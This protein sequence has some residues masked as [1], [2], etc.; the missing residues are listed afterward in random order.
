MRYRNSAQSYDYGDQYATTGEGTYDSR[1]DEST[2]DASYSHDK[3]SS[4]YTGASRDASYYAKGTYKT[5][6]QPVLK[7]ATASETSIDANLDTK[8]SLA[9]IVEVNFKSDYLPL[10]KIATP[11]NIAAIQMNAT[12][13][14][15]KNQAQ[16][17]QSGSTG[18]APAAGTSGSATSPTTKPAP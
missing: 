9:G 17:R 4:D 2:Q 3:D 7:L 11:E 12:P 5:T 6:S 14:I 8:A 18:I 15:A 10:D 16:S 13:G 1:S